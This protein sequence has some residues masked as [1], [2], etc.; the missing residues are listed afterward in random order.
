MFQALVALLS[1][2]TS[3]VLIVF[4]GGNTWAGTM[5]TVLWTVGGLTWMLVATLKGTQRAIAMEHETERI[6]PEAVSGWQV[7]TRPQVSPVEAYAPPTGT[8][9]QRSQRAQQALRKAQVGA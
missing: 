2:Y 9:K 5:L 1:W 6:E 8:A 7:R 3:I 4:V